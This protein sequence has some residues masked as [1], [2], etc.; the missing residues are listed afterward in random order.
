[1]THTLDIDELK[2]K[3]DKR[4]K[5]YLEEVY[6]AIKWRNSDRYWLNPEARTYYYFHKEGNVHLIFFFNPISF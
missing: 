5:L 2:K 6:K 4:L 1:M 3:P